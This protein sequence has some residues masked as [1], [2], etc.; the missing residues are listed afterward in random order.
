VFACAIIPRMH[1]SAPCVVSLTWVLQ[2]TQGEV[3]DE[4]REPLEFV[5]GGHDLLAKVEQAMDGQV[6]G[7][8]TLLHLEPEHAFGDYDSTLVCFEERVLFAEPVEVGMQFE[9]L[10][11]GAGSVDMPGDVIYTVTEV[12]PSHI[13]LDG[14]HPLAG[15]ALRLALKVVDVRAATSDEIE[16]G[17]VDSGAVTALPSPRGGNPLH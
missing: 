6:A 10:P 15:M 14:N 8:E 4:L 2:D 12:F 16:S 9:G 7:F 11:E 17:S 13:V 3:I 5:F 1:I